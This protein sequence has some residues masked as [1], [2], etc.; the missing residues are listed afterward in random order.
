MPA[1]LPWLRK[2]PL[3]NFQLRPIKKKAGDGNKL[4]VTIIKYLLN[5]KY[6]A[7]AS[8]AAINVAAI[9]ITTQELASMLAASSTPL[10]SRELFC[11]CAHRQQHSRQLY[12]SEQHLVLIKDKNSETIL[13]YINKST[14]CQTSCFG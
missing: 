13:Q 6:T 12:C 5:F 3:G 9:V 11:S 14:T 10:T 8:I 1:A 2:A 4:N 7:E